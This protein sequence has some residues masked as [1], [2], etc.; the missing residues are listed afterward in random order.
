MMVKTVID[1]DRVSKTLHSGLGLSF[2]CCSKTNI[3]FSCNTP[4][5]LDRIS[6]D[7]QSYEY[8]LNLLRVLRYIDN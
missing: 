4:G 1:K 2:R 5:Q 8:F 7:S 6:E 3:I